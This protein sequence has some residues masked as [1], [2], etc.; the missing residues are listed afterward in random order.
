MTA[1]L[2]PAFV[3]RPAP[4]YADMFDDFTAEELKLLPQVKRFFEC[5]EGDKELRENLMAGKATPEQLALLREIGITFDVELLAPMW[6]HGDEFFRSLYALHEGEGGPEAADFLGQNP[7]IDLWARFLLRK[8]HLY[9]VQRKFCTTTPSRSPKYSAWRQRRLAATRSELGVYGWTIDHPSVAIELAEGCSVGCYFCA[10]DAPKLSKLYDYNAPENVELFRGVSKALVELLGWSAGHTLLYWSTEPADNPNYI[11]FMR[12][13]EQITGAT[14][15]TATARA[16]EKWVG[17]LI[18]FYSRGPLPWPRISVLTK[19]LMYKLHKKF[20]P[21]QARD[22]VM[23]MQ[24]KDSEE[25]RAKVPGGR[26]K[27]LARLTQYKDLRETEVDKKPDDHFV[28]QGSIACVSGF[29]INMLARTVKLI[30]PC[31]TT[32]QYRYGYRVFAEATF[33]DADDF[34]RIINDMAGRKMV[35]EPYDEMPMRFRDDLRY[36]EKP[37]GFTVVS[38]NQ[39]HHCV[40][41]RVQKPL[42][43]LIA[44]GTYTYGEIVDRLISEGHDPFQVVAV[45]KGLFDQ[46]FLD[47]LQVEAPASR[48]V[49]AVLTPA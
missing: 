38:P 22:M 4:R 47:E 35:L 14:V 3:D 29:L 45:I 7:I 25:F 5:F 24:Q 39:V 49:P 19:S 28:P 26:E 34:R 6:Q 15:C 17:D 12:E 42:G 13:F 10:F 27:M 36:R 1:Q 23:L 30:S 33:E 16:D 37:D 40:G 21:E 48:Q 31:Y 41:H 18:E 11:D 32:M 9:Q 44:E 20:T 2:R 46:G 8:A 43:T